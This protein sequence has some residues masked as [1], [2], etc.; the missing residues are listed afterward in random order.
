[1]NVN[2]RVQAR[3]NAIKGTLLQAHISQI[4]MGHVVRELVSRLVVATEAV[5]QIDALPDAMCRFALI[6]GVPLRI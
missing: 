6:A 1:M 3:N 2:T 4:Q 5:L